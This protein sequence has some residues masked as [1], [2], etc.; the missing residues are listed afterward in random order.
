VFG[1]VRHVYKWNCG[2]D[3]DCAQEKMDLIAGLQYTGNKIQLGTK[4]FPTLQRFDNR[5]PL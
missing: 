2:D 1:H 4:L 3:G 5:F